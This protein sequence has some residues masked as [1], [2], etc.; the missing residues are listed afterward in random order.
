MI[1][2]PD[3]SCTHVVVCINNCITWFCVTR[4]VRYD[5]RYIVMSWHTNNG[6]IQP[7]K[8]TTYDKNPCPQLRGKYT[9]HI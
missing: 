2:L 4:F 9:V 5:T 1:T 8:G 6:N 3:I 7:R